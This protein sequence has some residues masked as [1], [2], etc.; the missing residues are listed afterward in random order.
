MTAIGQRLRRREDARF[1]TGQGRYLDDMAFAG[2]LVA[3]FVRSPHAH[4]LIRGIDASAALAVPGVAMVATGA[5]LAQWVA[6]AR[7]APPVAGLLAVTNEAMPVDRVRFDGDLVAC[8]VARDRMAAEDAAEQIVVDYEPLA[9]VTSAEAA[10]AAGAPLVDPALGTNVVATQR[11]AT[12]DVEGRLATAFRVVEA[13]FHQHRQTHAPMEP[14]GCCAIWDEGQQHLTMHIGNQAPHPYRTA[15]AGRLGLAESQITVISPD[16]GGAF[17]QKIVLQREDL[18]CAALSR[19]L[20]RPVRWREDRGE[21]LLASA[22]AREQ[23]VVARAAVDPDGR[24]TALAVEVVEDFGAY[25]FFP[26]NYLTRMMV[27]SLTGPYRID[28]YSYDMKIVLTNK[29]GAAPMR[30]P[31]AM[32]SWVMDGTLDAVARALDLDPIAVRC[33]NM[34]TAADLPF[35]MPEGVAM[36]DVTPWLTFDQAL[37]AFDVPAF[38]ARQQADRARGIYR[39]LGV[40]SVVESSTYGSAFYKLS[41][42]P[43][44]GY[45][46]GWVKVA[47][48]GAVDASCGLM[49]SG[50]GYETALAQAVAGGLGVAAET[51]RMRMGNTDVAP[52]GMGSRGARGGTVGG[53]VL[54]LAGQTLQRKIRDIGAALLGLNSGEDLRLADGRLERML[55][56]AWVDA[57]YSLADI[58]R[59][60]YFDP[61][62]LP[63]GMEPG[64]EAHRAYDPPPMTYANATHLC[65]VVV[66]VETGLVTPVRYVLADDCGTMLNPMIVEGQQHGAV[67][68][69]LSGALRERVVYDADG[70]NVT[71]S[72]MDYGIAAAADLPAIEIVSHHSPN[73][74][75]PTGSKG[76]SEGGVMGA[77]GAVTL[78]VNDALAPFGVVADRQPLSPAAVLALLRG[79]L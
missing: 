48:S 53:S 21:N 15:L 57:G 71:G 17:G 56:G 28:A 1:L 50:Q 39:G 14:R 8:V 67:A 6:P 60:A 74:R 65:E 63:P 59:I 66:D 70:H 36:Q 22:H 44:S 25:C 31:M 62:R 29:C 38:R 4:A 54:F 16:V 5:D 69:G 49:G 76:M 47:P 64:L 46:A 43:G 30:A 41:G 42:I 55:D 26:A 78:A 40:C 27:L 9:L 73:T 13:R 68:M 37:E 3:R 79:R 77:V 52:Y 18:T 7:F 12:G 75:T 2:A 34:L 24:V 61:A 72:L 35:P 11:D 58:A 32:G 19:V 45:E 51:V 33:R 23:T 20:K 10:M